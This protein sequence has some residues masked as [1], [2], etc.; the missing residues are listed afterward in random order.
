[1]SWNF[2]YSAFGR[3]FRYL[4]HIV[5]VDNFFHV[6]RNVNDTV[7]YAALEML[8]LTCGFSSELDAWHSSK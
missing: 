4:Q 2:N 6:I 8:L 7:T 1:M 3:I 5:D